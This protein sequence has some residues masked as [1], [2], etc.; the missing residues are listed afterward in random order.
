MIGKTVSHYKILEKLGEGGMGQVYKAEDTKLQRIVALKFLPHHLV[1][2]K[3]IKER[4]FHEARA[5]SALN[6]PNIITIHDIHEEEGEVFLV[7]ECVDGVL[8]SDKLKDGPLKQPELISIATGIADGLNAAHNADITHRDIKSEN[9]IITKEG[10]PKIIDFGLAKQKGMSQITQDGSTL[11]TQGYMSPEQV[12]GVEADR[13]SDIFSFGVVLYQMATGKLPFEGEHE[14]A[15][16]YS[17]VNEAPIPVTTHNPNLDEELQR[18]INKALEKNVKDRYQHADDLLADL[19]KL[20]K[21]TAPRPTKAK[22][23]VLRNLLYILGA[24]SFG[25]SIYLTFIKKDTLATEPILSPKSIAVLPFTSIDRTEESEIFGDGIHDDI[26]TQLSK[27]HDLKVI[28]RTSVMHYRNTNKKI[29]EIAEELN[30]GSIL[31]GSVRRAGNRIRIVA[32]L[33]DPKTEEHVWAETYDRD[34]ADIF[35]IQSDVANKIAGALQAT[36]T[37]EEKQSI[38]ERPTD[39]LEAYEFYQQG[40]IIFNKGVALEY[41]ESAMALFEKAVELDPDFVMAYAMLCITHL[42]VYWYLEQ[43]PKEHLQG[44]KLALDK[45]KKLDPNHSSINVAEGYYYYHGFRDYDKAIEK[46]YSALQE[47][48]NDSDLLA[49][50]GFVNRRQGTLEEALEYLKE[51]T[52][53]DPQSSNKAWEAGITA[54][55]L[56][57]W[58]VAEQFLIRATLINPQ[59]GWAY[60]DRFYLAVEGKGNFQ[61]GRKILAEA[62]KYNDSKETVMIGMRAYV[63]YMNRNYQKALKILNEYGPTNI[64]DDSGILYEKGRIALA[65]NQRELTTSYFDSLRTLLIKGRQLTSGAWFYHLSLSRAYAGLGMKEKFLKEWKL[66]ESLMPFH[67]D[68]FLG[69]TN[70]VHKI[71]QLIWLGE[72]DRAIDLVDQMLSMPSSLTINGL[73]LSPLYDPIRDNPRFQEVLKKYEG[74]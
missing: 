16:L 56:R 54:L 39:N 44:A 67:K 58:G 62:L 10:L 17:I 55:Y 40:K 51:A 59:N 36:L 61:E 8:L 18:I 74:K 38:D 35:A 22:R 50:I 57:N 65:L 66:Y 23:P 49:A 64:I 53:L 25:L 71:E 20:K 34:Y 41:I 28:A 46:F 43:L 32:Q 14:A 3:S 31:E 37:L 24:V 72:Y 52:D 21:G 45:A 15:V 9:I 47:Y 26:L 30:V 42:R 69:A 4:F 6:H 19:R 13:R 12:Q 33:I 1:A 5:A 29:K 2:G 48:P 63:E 60:L 73:K 27:I 68:V 70:R 7:M 11:G